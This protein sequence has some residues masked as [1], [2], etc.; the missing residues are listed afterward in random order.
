MCCYK[1]YKNIFIKFF[2]LNKFFFMKIGI[3]VSELKYIM[4]LIKFGV[5]YFLFVKCGG[6]FIKG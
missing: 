1:F 2:Y 4:C 3:V 5:K 6:F